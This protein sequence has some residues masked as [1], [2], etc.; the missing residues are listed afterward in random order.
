MNPII[1]FLGGKLSPIDLH[2]PLIVELMELKYVDKAVFIITAGDFLKLF[3]EQ[4]LIKATVKKYNIKIYII[5]YKNIFAKIYLFLRIL[6]GINF[7]FYKKSW[8]INLDNN[9]LMFQIIAKYNKALFKGIFCKTNF[10]LMDETLFNYIIKKITENLKRPKNRIIDCFDADIILS[11]YSTKY[12]RYK[13]KSNSVIK[14]IGSPKEFKNWNEIVIQR[15]KTDFEKNI[16][17]NYFFW[18]L[19]VL[20]RNEKNKQFSSTELILDT[21]RILEE[22]DFPIQIVFRYHPT[23]DRI[24]MD[25]IIYNSKYKNYTFSNAHPHSL[26]AY[27]QFIFS[28]W[29][30]TLFNDAASRGC[31][32][33]QYT[34]GKNN[35][36][37][38]DS[39]GFPI[40]SIYHPV[41]DNFCNSRQMF[42]DVLNN[43]SNNISDNY[44]YLKHDRTNY[45]N[46]DI[47]N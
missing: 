6:I 27:S 46:M 41:V 17:K 36:A 23:T 30:T 13:H 31:P 32:V 44:Y 4:K 8:F 14:Y 15:G 37:V 45:N 22:L 42:I 11:S 18:P 28:N 39:R 12:F 38:N 5:D 40:A 43:H 9:H 2:L 35:I 21:L 26:I 10:S 20:E 25:E 3:N 1:L 24:K 47:I 16:S 33:V 7:V 19:S 29:G 34:T